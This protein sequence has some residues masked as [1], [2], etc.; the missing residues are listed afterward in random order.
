M[1][2]YAVIQWSYNEESD[3]DYIIEVVYY[4]WEQSYFEY[5][6]PAACPSMCKKKGDQSGDTVVAPLRV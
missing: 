6:S 2:P 1:M 5:P 3:I 4:R